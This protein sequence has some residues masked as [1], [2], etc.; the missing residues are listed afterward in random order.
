MVQTCPADTARVIAELP[1]PAGPLIALAFSPDR[2]L[3]AAGVRDK[4]GRIWDVG[5]KLGERSVLGTDGAPLSAVAF[6]PNGRLLATGSGGAG[7]LIVVYDVTQ[8]RPAE[9]AILR[10]ARGPV[11]AVAFSADNKFVAACGDDL[12][13][14]VWEFAPGKSPS[15]KALLPGHAS[16][17][18]AAAFA[19]DGKGLAT[20]SR[21]GTVRLW[22]LGAIRSTGRATLPH[23]ADVGTLAYS[24]ANT[25]VTGCADGVVRV[26]DVSGPSPRVRTQ[27][28]GHSGAVHRVIVA[29]G[30]TLVSV[31]ADGRVFHWKPP[32]SSPVREW[33][34][35]RPASPAVALTGDGRYL[36]DAAPDGKLELYRVADKR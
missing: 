35:P 8:K 23:G 27:L 11:E 7:G 9:A 10:G 26:W 32:S 14:R 6:A 25:L 31:G 36:A 22:T 12:T 19:P 16:A 5:G 34:L 4:A 17:V 13:V 33:K 1:G 2:T 21:D 20:G 28:A 24:D 3:L 18:T 29:S 15:P 30:G